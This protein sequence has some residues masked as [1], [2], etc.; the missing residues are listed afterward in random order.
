M[1]LNQSYS[2]NF[3]F[4]I[5]HFS[6]DLKIPHS[7]LSILLI[8]KKIDNECEQVI[9]NFSPKNDHCC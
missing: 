6:F 3:S 7:S 9:N 5:F 2:N 1:S 8:F 4:F